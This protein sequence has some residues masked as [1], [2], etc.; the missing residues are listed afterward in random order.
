MPPA[1]PQPLSS[2][3]EK[4]LIVMDWL[5]AQSEYAVRGNIRIIP[6]S[7]PFNDPTWHEAERIIL[8]LD[9]QK[10]IVVTSAAMFKDIFEE[11]KPT[12]PR[13]V[14]LLPL[15]D[16]KKK[17]LEKRWQYHEPQ[18]QAAKQKNLEIALAQ[19][20]NTF[21]N[22]EKKHDKLKVTPNTPKQI[23]AMQIS[24][25]SITG[26]VKLNDLFLLSKPKVGSEQQQ[27]FA[28]LY[29]HPNTTHTA[30]TL[31][32]AGLKFS[33][34]PSHFVR[35][36]GFVGDLAKVFFSTSNQGYLFR[37]PITAAMLQDLGFKHIR[38]RTK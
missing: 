37:N 14:Q 18:R 29:K 32:A 20:E 27:L 6:K 23:H 8:Q 11:I 16:K 30:A 13:D 28:Y 22:S 25:S 36:M 4:V 24:Y 19:I 33:G 15:F 21:G 9:E 10:A 5:V 26:E 3:E 12:D 2:Y 1:P 31:K 34:E 17:E 35:D 7:Y 38:L